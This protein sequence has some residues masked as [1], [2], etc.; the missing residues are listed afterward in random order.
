MGR[1][2]EAGSLGTSS[3]QRRS[4]NG[5]CWEARGTRALILTSKTF[6]FLNFRALR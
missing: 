3:S 5:L 4:G 2:R 1:C 6:K